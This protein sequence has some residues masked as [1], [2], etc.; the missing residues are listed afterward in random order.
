M[1]KIFSL[2]LLLVSFYCFAK[3]IEIVSTTSQIAAVAE[4]IGKPYVNVAVLIPPGICPGHYEIKP[5]DIKKLCDGAILLYHGWEGFIGDISKSIAG[6]GAKIFKINVPGSWLIPDIQIKAA[7]KI[8]E[9]LSSIEP[10]RKKFFENNL[11]SYKEKMLQLDKKIKNFVL[12]SNL[13][14]TKAICSVMQKDFLEYLGFDVVDCFQR[15][16]EIDPGTIKRIIDNIKN[17]NIKIVVSNLQSGTST[18]KMLA[19]RTSITHVIISNFP[20]GLKN[21]K[22]IE[23]TVMTN[24]NLLSSGLKKYKN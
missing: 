6:S 4:E 14:D 7:E 5:G 21:T 17:H 19:E 10:E 23:D 20:G 18:G 1:K 22:T 16:E 8:T 24:L 12:T 3:N 2:A 15:D 9:V 13:K 11:K